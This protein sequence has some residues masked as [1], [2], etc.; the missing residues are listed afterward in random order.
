MQKSF[1][2]LLPLLLFCNAC[3]DEDQPKVLA[4]RIILDST[5][6]Y[7]IADYPKLFNAAGPLREK[8]RY[9]SPGKNLLFTYDS[10]PPGLYTFDMP[11][12]LGQ[13]QLMDFDLRSDTVFHLSLKEGLVLVDS[14]ALKELEAADTVTVAYTVRGCFSSYY[15]KTILV[16]NKETG[17]YRLNA[18]SG[19]PFSADERIFSVSRTVS[20]SVVKAIDSMLV[21]SKGHQQEHNLSTVSERVYIVVGKKLYTFQDDFTTKGDK[22]RNLYKDFKEKYIY[23]PSED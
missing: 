6:E 8:A 10:V 1:A 15:E 14:F 2:L 17:K 19:R 3:S 16:K 11:V 5:F 9:D 12:L 7:C 23:K 13:R 18:G 22:N 20:N 21:Y 4:I